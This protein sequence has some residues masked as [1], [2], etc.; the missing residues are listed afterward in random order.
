MNTIHLAIARPKVA[1]M[2]SPEWD[3]DPNCIVSTGLAFLIHVS[4]E[5]VG[6]L[7][8]GVDDINSWRL[9]RQL[10]LHPLQTLAGGPAGPHGSHCPRGERVSHCGMLPFCVLGSKEPSRLLL[11]PFPIPSISHQFTFCLDLQKFTSRQTAGI[12]ECLSGKGP[13]MDEE[14]HSWTFTLNPDCLGIPC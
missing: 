13:G 7:H 11:N 14:C 3:G 2:T 5:C 9:V 6:K 8:S 1:E 10:D 12:P 4:S